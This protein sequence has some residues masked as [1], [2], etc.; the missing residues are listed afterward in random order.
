M[1]FVPSLQFQ[2]AQKMLQQKRIDGEIDE[3][4]YR[5]LLDELIIKEVSAHQN[6][7]VDLTVQEMRDAASQSLLA[8][9]QEQKRAKDAEELALARQNRQE[10]ENKR[11]RELAL[12]RQQEEEADRQTQARWTY[13]YR[14]VPGEIVILKSRY[15]RAKQIYT[16]LQVA[17]IVFSIAT[18]TLVGTDLFPRAI[19]LICS[20]FAAIAAAALSTFRMREHNYSYYQTISH[21][22]SEIHDYDQRVGNYVGLDDEQAYRR[23][24]AR[25][26]EIKQQYIS[27]EL[28]M[29]KSAGSAEGSDGQNP[30]DANSNANAEAGADQ[31]NSPRGQISPQTT[32]DEEEKK[33]A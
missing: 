1:P 5:R 20:G 18:T 13:R 3:I 19:A 11:R 32:Q 29:W 8:S 21:M 15:E 4:E 2:Q 12:K 24:A 16:W 30:P 31:G 17:S 22:E 33:S 10:E 28:A 25:I 6:V 27:Q 9:E 7:V 26:S 23:F 14:T